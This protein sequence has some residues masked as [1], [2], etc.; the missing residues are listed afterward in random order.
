VGDGKSEA[1]RSPYGERRGE[2]GAGD[3]KEEEANDKDG[4]A[5]ER[6]SG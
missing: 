1:G 3:A 2:P 4:L 6:K 5:R